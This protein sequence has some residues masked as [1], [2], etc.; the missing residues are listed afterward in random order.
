MRWKAIVRFATGTSHQKQQIPCQDYGA[1]CLIDNVIIG[2]V[3]DGAG[4]A[5]YS[6]FGSQLAV[7][8]T[9][10]YLSGQ[11]QFKKPEWKKQNL[12]FPSQEQAKTLFTNN[13]KKV[14]ET[15][16][17]KAINDGY[18]LNN[19]ACT[20]LTFIATPDWM[21]AMQIGDGFIVTRTST[22][23]YE[24]VFKPDKGEYFNETTF[25]TSSNAIQDMKIDVKL[26]QQKFICAA[27][28]GLETVA[29]V[30]KEWKAFSPFFQ[31]LEQYIE[32]TNNPEQED[33]D[34]M[35]FLNSDRLNARTD[36]D[37]TLLICSYVL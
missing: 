10:E 30:L 18:S 31:P 12:T 8:T 25:I 27:T 2:A 32:E 13:M 15:L 3:S 11:Q 19:L 17:Q 16:N 22:G 35:S 14:I 6:H 26:G 4:S 28:D 34:L 33:G 20:L 21:I 1:Y 37:K 23:N 29:I 5:K 9:L 36:D 7:K 24:L